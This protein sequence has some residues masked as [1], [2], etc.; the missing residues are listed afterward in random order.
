V[1][2]LLDG[3]GGRLV[4]H[5]EAGRDDAGGDDR[6]HRVAGLHHVVE[7]RQHALG[8]LGL[9]GELDRDLGDHRQ[10]AL[11]AGDSGSRS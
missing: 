3:R 9:G 5:L 8:E 2:E 7:G 1:H 10:H 6:G 4:H 11:R